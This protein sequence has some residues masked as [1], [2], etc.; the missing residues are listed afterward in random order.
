MK[1][2]VEIKQRVFLD[3]LKASIADLHVVNAQLRAE[4]AVAQGLLQENTRSLTQKTDEVEELKAKVDN[5]MQEVEALQ[6]P[7]P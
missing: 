6:R 7:A 3:T 2:A 1:D 5:L 4:L